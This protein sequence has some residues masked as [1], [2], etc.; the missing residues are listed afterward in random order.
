MPLALEPLPCLEG[1]GAFALRAQAPQ[2]EL[3][4]GLPAQAEL[5]LALSDFGAQTTVPGRRAG[6]TLVFAQA[7]VLDPIFYRSPVGQEKYCDAPL[8]LK[9]Q[10]TMRDFYYL[11]GSA[12][13]YPQRSVVISGK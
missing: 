11:P 1:L 6:A 9:V 10:P 5:L 4:P 3:R 12:P 8:A 13:T 7:L 2:R